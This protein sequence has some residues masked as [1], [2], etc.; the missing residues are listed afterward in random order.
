MVHR[1]DIEL[2]DR[3]GAAEDL[4]GAAFQLSASAWLRSERNSAW[5]VALL[6]EPFS[7]LDAGNRRAFATHLAAMLSGR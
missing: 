3:S 6:D 4:A 5:S 7:Q 1:L 2:S